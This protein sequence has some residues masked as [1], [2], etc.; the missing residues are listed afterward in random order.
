MPRCEPGP[1]SR[2]S[3]RGSAGSPNDWRAISGQADSLGRKH[4]GAD[5]A[6]TSAQLVIVPSR[7]TGLAPVRE[8][9]GLVAAGQPRPPAALV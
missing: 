9:V 2:A 6:E 8:S 5:Q 3:H 7:L 1:A 4:P